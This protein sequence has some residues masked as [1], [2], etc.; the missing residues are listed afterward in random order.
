MN[1]QE[2]PHHTH[3]SPC[4]D[5][6]RQ[7]IIYVRVMTIIQHK[8]M[9]RMMAKIGSPFPR[10][11]NKTKWYLLENKSRETDSNDEPRAAHISFLSISHFLLIFLAS[12]R[13]KQNPRPTR[14]TWKKL[15]MPCINKIFQSNLLVADWPGNL[16]QS[17]ML[18]IG[19]RQEVFHL[20]LEWRK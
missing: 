6:F 3:H 5:V 11:Q 7:S 1:G 10:R 4:W 13:D 17:S 2:P 15:E 14:K 19:P 9:M 12:Q 16:S 20:F 8:E 18:S